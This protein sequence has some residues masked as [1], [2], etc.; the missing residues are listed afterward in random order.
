MKMKNTSHWL[1]PALISAIH[2]LGSVAAHC[3]WNPEGRGGA[4]ALAESPGAKA[5]SQ[6]GHRAFAEVIRATGPMVRV[7]LLRFST[8]YQ[9]HETDLVYYGYRYY[10]ASTGRWLSRDPIGERGFNLLGRIKGTGEAVNRYV[11]VANNA[12]GTFD[13]DGLK[14]WVCT[15]RADPPL[16]PW[17]RHAYYW[18][19][20]AGVTNR[21]CGM[22]SSSGS[23]SA[24]NS[25]GNTGPVE[26]GPGIPVPWTSNKGKAPTECYPVDDSDAK[27]DAVMKCCHDK[28]NSGVFFPYSHD[29]HSAVDRCLT[30]NHLDIPPH[31]RGDVI[32]NHVRDIQ[33][34]CRYLLEGM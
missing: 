12:V 6:C 33:C 5:V 20:R 28:A 16:P 14:I 24:G 1:R 2:L 27:E 34:A 4:V 9:D 25:S 26:P 8:K 23:G 13:P 21:E 3:F 19:D 11:F 7:N 31:S 30:E 22:E 18:D 15:V 17:S 32:S 29:C 10:N